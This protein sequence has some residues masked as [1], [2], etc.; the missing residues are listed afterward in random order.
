MKRSTR[1]YLLATGVIFVARALL[2]RVEVEGDSMLPTLRPGDRLLMLRG[3][4]SR[5]GD[6]VAV[7]D[8]RTPAR[9]LVKRVAAVGTEGV[10]VLG[11]NP[12][13]S[14][15]SRLLGPVP[16]VAIRGRAV[17]RYLPDSR[18]GPVA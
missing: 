18:R 5:V 10:T 6:I 9:T 17:Y 1:H 16:A 12:A 4:R 7:T 2:F 3:R 14:T 15:D 13:A 11:D 8:L